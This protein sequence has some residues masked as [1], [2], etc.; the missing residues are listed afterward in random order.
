[1]KFVAFDLETT[2]IIPNVD[3]IVEIGAVEFKNGKPQR[4][5]TTLV[6]PKKPI[7]PSASKINGITDDMVKGKPTIEKVMDSFTDFCGTSVL[8]AHNA[9]FDYQFLLADMK[10]YQTSSPRGVVLDTYILSKK[11]FPGLPSY[12]LESLAKWLKIPQGT[13]HRAEEDATYCG[14]LFSHILREVF[15]KATPV[16]DNLV[17]LTGKPKVFFPKIEKV[18]KQR[19]LFSE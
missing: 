13:F 17:N 12:K 11:V 18:Y 1:M 10:R 19:G 16:V 2:G 14:L 6:D 9:T 3:R 4:K 7:P 8:V 15:K 5:F